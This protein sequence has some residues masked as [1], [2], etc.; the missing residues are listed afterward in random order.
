MKL[1]EMT[2]AQLDNAVQA[3]YDKMYDDY[4]RLNESDSCC[5]NCYHYSDGICECLERVMT[6]DER[7]QAEETDD[8]SAIEKDPDDYCDNW[9]TKESWDD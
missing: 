2:D 3:H 9:E 1:Y 4:C 6:N 7:K 5:E 8:W